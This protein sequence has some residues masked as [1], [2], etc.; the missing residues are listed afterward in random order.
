[1]IL[2]G[3][4][5]KIEP[6]PNGTLKVFGI[7]SSGA[8][9]TAGEIVSPDAMRDALPDYL[10]FGAI[11]EM[12]EARAAGS[13]LT[14]QVDDDGLTRISAHI[15]DPVA[16]AK[17][18]AGVYKGLSIGGKVI[19]RDAADPSLITRLR[20]D[21]ISL[22]D[23]P[24]NPEAVIDLWKAQAPPAH[25]QTVND[26]APD[27]TYADPANHKYPLDT[28]QR[29]RAAWAAVTHPDHQAAYDAQTLAEIEARIAAAWRAK[30][31]PAG[32]PAAAKLAAAED[33][34]KFADLTERLTDALAKAEVETTRLAKLCAD[35]TAEIER[36]K[37][38]PLPP[39]TAGSHLAKAIGK[40]EDV[41][42]PAPLSDDQ[43]AKALDAMTPAERAHLL[44]KAALSRPIPL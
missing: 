28:P 36:L 37:R 23:R 33:L 9:D 24:C 42:G 18:R 3:D 44:M 7:A 38:Q 1:M 29:I 21:E 6:Q 35:Q 41:G 30:I 8:R 4:L 27:P 43:I 2:Y 26:Q 19:A 40:E 5:T 32:P 13:T 31:D 25:E 39:R 12:H 16:V 20:L 15:V 11:R 22:V 34:R 10:A 17:V 14:A